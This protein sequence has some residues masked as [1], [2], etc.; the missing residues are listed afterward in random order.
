MNMR[1]YGIC[2]KMRGG[3]A[4]LDHVQA[5]SPVPVEMMQEVMEQIGTITPE[6]MAFAERL[7]ADWKKAFNERVPLSMSIGEDGGYDITC[8]VPDE[9]LDTISLITG[10]DGG[11]LVEEYAADHLKNVCGIEAEVVS[12]DVSRSEDPAP[13]QA[14]KA[15]AYGAPASGFSMDDLSEEPED[16]EFDDVTAFPD[17]EVGGDVPDEL[18]AAPQEQPAV[19]V[20]APEVQTEEPVQEMEDEAP[21]FSP[22]DLLEGDDEGIPLDGP[23]AGDAGYGDDEP[24]AE[25]EGYGPDEDEGYIPDDEPETEPEP[26]PEPEVPDRDPKAEMD[27][28]LSGIYR[29][30]VS[31]ITDKK[32]DERLGL[33]IAQ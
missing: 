30:L 14:A 24:Y 13:V 22:E 1:L 21:G 32:L 5:D 7:D 25:D 33:K 18:F 3:P 23:D 15:P 19:Q 16:P 17:M 4:L 31:N 27:E 28:A 8:S 6:E 12:V 29:E 11:K 2:F 20:Q 26:E 10:L 9:L